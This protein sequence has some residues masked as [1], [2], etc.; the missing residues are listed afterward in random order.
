L[1]AR[2]ELAEF[3]GKRFIVGDVMTRDVQTVYR[4]APLSEVPGMM[5]RNQL[6]CL[7]VVERGDTLVGITTEADFVKF[8]ERF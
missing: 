6:G 4:D 8:C 2:T 1:P 7:P 3:L 5:R